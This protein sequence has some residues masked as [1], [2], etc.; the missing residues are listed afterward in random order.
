MSGTVTLPLVGTV[1]TKYVWVSAGL[2]AAVVGWSYW[3][4][5]SNSAGPEP[6]IEG[7]DGAEVPVG[8]DGWSNVPGSTGNASGAHDDAGV[9]DTVPEWTANVVGLLSS[10]DWDAGYVYTTLGKWLAGEPLSEP[11]KQLVMAALAAAGQPPGGPYPI[12]TAMP[13]VQAPPPVYTPPFAVP[14]PEPGHFYTTS[15]SQ[16]PIGANQ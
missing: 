7:I 15:S 8:E 4:K 14:R 9:I 11:E 3:R 1:P 6:I 12:K 10:S 5:R 2:V 13:T 16:N